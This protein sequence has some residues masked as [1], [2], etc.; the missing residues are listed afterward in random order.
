M[1]RPPKQLS[2]AQG[3]IDE[4]E[5]G[6]ADASAKTIV[7]AGIMGEHKKTKWASADNGASTMRMDCVLYNQH[8]CI[9]STL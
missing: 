4:P 8:V 3:S 9:F 5:Y 6:K 7:S 2:K 1:F